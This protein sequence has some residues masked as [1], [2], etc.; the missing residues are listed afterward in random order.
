MAIKQYIQVEMHAF[1]CP[2]CNNKSA[3]P[4]PNSSQEERD[5]KCGF[6]NWHPYYFHYG[7]PNWEEQNIEDFQREQ[8]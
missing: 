3:V 2:R 1:D 4:F 7:N 5:I 6:C 8:I